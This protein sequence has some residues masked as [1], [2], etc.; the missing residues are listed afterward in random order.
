VYVYGADWAMSEGIDDTDEMRVH[1]DSGDVL[2]KMK[3][4]DS[5]DPVV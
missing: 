5:M 2:R 4:T 1:T 3:E